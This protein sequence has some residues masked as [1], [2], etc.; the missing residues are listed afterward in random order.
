MRDRAEKKTVQDEQNEPQQKRVRLS[1]FEDCHVQETMTKFH[2]EMSAI[3]VAA[4]ATCHKTFPGMKMAAKHD[5]CIRCSR[6]RGTPKLYS[7]DNNMH[8]GAI[9]PQL[10]V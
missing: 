4:C 1:V 2:H 3:E 8:P 6:D 7:E 5:E 9:P 10:K